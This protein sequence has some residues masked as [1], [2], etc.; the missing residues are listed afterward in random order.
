MKTPGKQFAIIGIVVLTVTLGASAVFATA[1]PGYPTETPIYEGELSNATYLADADDS[2]LPEE[3]IE[4]RKSKDA[5]EFASRTN[6]VLDIPENA[7]AYPQ[8]LV[9]LNDGAP[10]CTVNIPEKSHYISVVVPG[11]EYRMLVLDGGGSVLNNAGLNVTQTGTWYVGNQTATD[12][13]EVGD[14]RA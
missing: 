11:G 3:K 13:T 10:V 7:T 8:S 6:L 4:C 1:S 5:G 14:E 2:D 9:L 12:V